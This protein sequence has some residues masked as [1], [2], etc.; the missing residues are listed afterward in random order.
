MRF[1][2]LFLFCPLIVFGQDGESIDVRVWD[3]SSVFVFMDNSGDSWT[4]TI[5]VNLTNRIRIDS[6]IVSKTSDIEVTGLI[7]RLQHDSINTPIFARV[8]LGT[9][10]PQYSQEF[11]VGNTIGW[12]FLQMRLEAYFTNIPP[13]TYDVEVEVKV[14]SGTGTIYNDINGSGSRF[15]KAIVRT[16]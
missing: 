2:L 6:V 3:V 8:R 10:T 11:T 14:N 16:Q 15:L 9:P 1:I 13:G 12:H 4:D 7:N 5:Y